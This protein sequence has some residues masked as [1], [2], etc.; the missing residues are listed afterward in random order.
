MC[1]A[2]LRYF[3]YQGDAAVLEGGGSLLP[4]ATGPEVLAAH[5]RRNRILRFT[6]GPLGVAGEWDMVDPKLL[7][8]SSS[9]NFYTSSSA[10]QS[11]VTT[12]GWILC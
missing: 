5:R 11:M 2:C 9:G 10:A 6:I 7:N 3:Y 8:S 12:P 1:F 4:R